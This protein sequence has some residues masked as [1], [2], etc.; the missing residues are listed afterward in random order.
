MTDA[1]HDFK[2]GDRVSYS[3]HSDSSPATVV[4][5]TPTRVYLRSDHVTKWSP[6][7]DC[8]G[9]EFREGEH[10]EPDMM[11]SWKRKAGLLTVQGGHYGGIYH[12][13]AAYRNP[14][15]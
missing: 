11:F 12:G 15:F 10:S 7:P 8:R 6:H 5:V 14:H 3:F 13:W 1:K 2:V 4:R 9:L